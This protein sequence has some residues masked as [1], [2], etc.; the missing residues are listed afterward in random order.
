MPRDQLVTVS[1]AER[2]Q[3]VQNVSLVNRTPTIATIGI[4]VLFQ[5]FAQGVQRQDPVRDNAN[6]LMVSSLRG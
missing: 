1:D 5:C 2:L 3:G 4:T 6:L